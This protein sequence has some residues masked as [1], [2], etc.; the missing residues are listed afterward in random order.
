M[1]AVIEEEQNTEIKDS[2]IS[3]VSQTNRDMID[4][5]FQIILGI[6]G[7]I[8]IAIEENR[9]EWTDTGIIDA[10]RKQSILNYVSANFQCSRKENDL[11]FRMMVARLAK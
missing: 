5:G 8:L 6:T 9:V 7:V 2:I 3:F 4:F 11:A 1:L 10:M